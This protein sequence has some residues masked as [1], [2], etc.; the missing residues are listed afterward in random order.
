MRL[1]GNIGGGL[2]G[3]G[4]MLKHVFSLFKSSMQA[5]SRRQSLFHVYVY[6]AWLLCG[7]KGCLC[8]LQTLDTTAENKVPAGPGTTRKSAQHRRETTCSEAQCTHGTAREVSHLQYVSVIRGDT[9]QLTLQPESVDL[10]VTSPPYWRKRDYGL[11]DQIGQE[12]T[13]EEYVDALLSALRNWRPCLRQTGSVFLNIGD[14]YHNGSLVDVP[15][16]VIAAA[17]LDDWIVRNRIIW[18]KSNGAPDPA[19]N[20]L[21]NRHEFIIHLTTG[22]DYYYDLF[23]FSEKYGTGANPGDVWMINPRLNGDEHLAPFP[24]EIAERA[25]TL[26]CPEQ[27]CTDCNHPRRRIVRRTRELNPDRPQARRAMELANEA[28]L[29]DE[30]IAAIQ[31]VGISDAG[32][33]RE[34]QGGAGR[35]SETVLRL[36]AEAK[37]VLGGYFREFTFPRRKSDGWTDC[38]C[39]HEFMPG[40]V[41]DPF[42]GTGTTLK[43]ARSMGRS[44]IGADLSKQSLRAF[45][46]IT[47][48]M[49]V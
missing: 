46:D 10:I 40:V 23:A 5:A 44:A 13:A 21:A 3:T 17:R 37:A 38:R 33:A 45:I 26:A 36:A 2:E 16:R 18:V 35:N 32:K 19:K 30:H 11:K 39:G 42:M 14:T 31:A 34:Y 49:F 7:K 27:V 28:G 43:A 4:G 47:D 25:I 9:R 20:R 29:T 8:T 41:L 48:A 24:A 22:R 1:S 12:S 6:Q 15:S